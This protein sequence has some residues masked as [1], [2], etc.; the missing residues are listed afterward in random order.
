MFGDCDVSESPCPPAAPEAVR[1]CADAVWCG[2]YESSCQQG[3]S[4][5]GSE[6]AV[7]AAAINMFRKYWMPLERRAVIQGRWSSLSAA[8]LADG[9][10]PLAG[11]DSDGPPPP[12]DRALRTYLTGTAGTGKSRTIRAICGLRR[13]KVL[14]AGASEEAVRDACVLAAPTGCASFQMKFGA[15]TLHKAFG[16]GIYYTGPTRD[17]QSMAFQRRLRRLRAASLIVMD[18]FSMIGRQMLG[19]IVYKFDDTLGAESPSE[20]GAAA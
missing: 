17:R 9:P 13:S 20:F 2:A 14:M 19:K 4:L 5:D 12:E 15:T 18:E 7:R 1:S 11:S 6:A 3:M 10:P 8:L 16:I